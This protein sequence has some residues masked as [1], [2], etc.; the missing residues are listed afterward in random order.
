MDFKNTRAVIFDLDG[1]LL[2]TL[3]DLMNAVNHALTVNGFPT[4]SR[5]EIRRFVGN[6][7]A[8]LVTRALPAG[9]EQSVFENAL[10]ETRKYYAP[11]C[12]ENTAP[13][14]GIHE[15]L[16]TL[17]EKGLRI[18]VVSNKPDEQV[19][20]LC[21]EEF[22]TMI[23]FASGAA[24]GFRLKPAPDTLIRCMEALGG[25]QF[26]TVYIG[27]SDVDIQTA[28]NAQIPCIS[29]LWGFRDKVFLEASGARLFAQTPSEILR[30]F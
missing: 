7:L 11:H 19:K 24:E 13:Y 27:D 15:M 25:D 2:D 21:R 14:P 29:V 18:G 22:G 1:T 20:A 16:R 23:E 10:S 3:T 12:K 6:G 5:E 28:A 17:S 30:F 4:R 8:K 9:I 26:S